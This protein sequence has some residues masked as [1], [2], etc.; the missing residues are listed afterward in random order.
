MVSLV[1]SKNEEDPIKIEGVA[2]I[3]MKKESISNA[4]QIPPQGNCLLQ[5]IFYRNNIS[6]CKCPMGVH[7]VGMISNCSIKNCGRS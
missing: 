7:H 4:Y 5:K 2:T 3:Q 6:S 1:S